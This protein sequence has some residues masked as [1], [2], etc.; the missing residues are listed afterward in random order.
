[1]STCALQAPADPEQPAAVDTDTL[2][3]SPGLS[4]QAPPLGLP[5][6]PRLLLPPAKAGSQGAVPP[7]AQQAQRGQAAGSDLLTPRQANEQQQAA[8]AWVSAQ[9]GSLPSS[10]GGPGESD[11]LQQ[12]EHLQVCLN[13][14]NFN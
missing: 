5:T 11:H 8:D 14:G 4:G 10:Y 12:L 6:E 2:P 9:Q 7:G 1:M 13:E 3:A